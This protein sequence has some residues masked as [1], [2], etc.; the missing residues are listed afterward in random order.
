MNG[1]EAVERLRSAFSTEIPAVL[2]SGDISEDTLRE[3]QAHDF[4]MLHKPVQ[5]DE[6][7]AV[8]SELVAGPA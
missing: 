1:I 5:A 7:R 3:V 2:L 6:L 4:T 8:I